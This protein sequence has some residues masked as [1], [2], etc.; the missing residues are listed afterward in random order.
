MPH[1]PDPHFDPYFD[2]F[3]TLFFS[4][5]QG[6]L[7]GEL[8]YGWGLAW[9]ETVDNGVNRFEMPPIDIRQHSARAWVAWWVT[10]AHRLRMQG[11][12]VLADVA[13]QQK[14]RDDASR[15]LLH[16]LFTTPPTPWHFRTLARPILQAQIQ[17]ETRRLR[18]DPSVTP[19]DRKARLGELGR[20]QGSLFT[21]L[22]DW[23]DEATNPNDNLERM[24]AY[25]PSPFFE[26]YTE[27]QDFVIA[28]RDGHG[29][30]P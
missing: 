27:A 15:Q 2:P 29:E 30:R 23:Q 1:R 28:W 10:L 19:A 9:R 21:L 26:D 22:R 6:E 8:K 3:S 17:E 4:L 25:W 7:K 18:D 20:R 14:L 13:R 11:I 24:N 12:G 5:T 16:L